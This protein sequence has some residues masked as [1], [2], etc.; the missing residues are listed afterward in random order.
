MDQQQRRAALRER[1]R[2]RQPAVQARLDKTKA[3]RPTKASIRKLIRTAEQMSEPPLVV[4]LT[5]PRSVKPGKA[6]KLLGTSGPFSVD[7]RPI[8]WENGEATAW[9]SIGSL[10]KWSRLAPPSPSQ[11]EQL[12]AD[13]RRELDF[14]VERT[15]GGRCRMAVET[16]QA[17]IESFDLELER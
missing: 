9:W 16:M 10:R 8:V 11:L 12:L 3:E 1:T 14:D 13:L 5:I 6:I 4:Q 17:R 7:G 15:G 2:A